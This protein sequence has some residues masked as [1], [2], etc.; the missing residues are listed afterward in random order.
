MAFAPPGGAPPDMVLRPLEESLADYRQRMVKQREVELAAE[1][2]K[3]KKIRRVQRAASVRLWSTNVGE[4]VGATAV[5][6]GFYQLQHWLG[7]IVGGVLLAV[8]CYLAGGPPP[9]RA[10][11]AE[12]A[13]AG[14]VNPPPGH[15][16]PGYR[17]GP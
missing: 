14:N 3:H 2:A 8:F 11:H 16:P 10:S 13:G 4:L 5:A 7:W 1:R 15:T 9:G 12:D 6:Y 17:E